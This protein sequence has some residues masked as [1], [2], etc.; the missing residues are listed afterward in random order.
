MLPASSL[1][2]HALRASSSTPSSAEPASAVLCGNLEDAIP[3]RAKQAACAGF[4]GSVKNT[5]LGDTALRVRVHALKSPWVLDDL[6]QTL[7]GVGHWI[8][9]VMIPKGGGPVGP[10]RCRPLPGAAGSAAPDQETHPL[11]CA[12]GNNR[13]RKNVEQNAKASLRLHGMSL[14]PADLTPSRGT[15]TARAG[16][17]NR[18]PPSA[19]RARASP[20]GAAALGQAA[21][22]RVQDRHEALPELRRSAQD[23]RG[24]RWKRR[25]SRKSSTT[26]D[27]RRVH[28][29]GRRPPARPGKRADENG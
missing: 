29:L 28:R 25:C 20:H 6:A 24:D 27:C 16:C 3:M 12:A 10:P 21:Q 1:R 11:A 15:K 13:R 9:A 17:G 26:C 4:V 8:E 19:R 14:G 7:A 2:C 5:D 23:H 22:A 18:H